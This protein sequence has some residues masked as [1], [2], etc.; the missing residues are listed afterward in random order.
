MVRVPCKCKV[1]KASG[2]CGINSACYN[3]HN[4]ICTAR[5]W[6]LV[7]RYGGVCDSPS[8]R[9]VRADSQ[10]YSSKLQQQF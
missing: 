5:C 4:K 6:L 3:S 7:R 9:Y 2:E 10:L 1:D 8:T